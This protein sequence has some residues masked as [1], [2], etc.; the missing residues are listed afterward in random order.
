MGAPQAHEEL[1]G[2]V[3]GAPAFYRWRLRKLQACAT[4]GVSWFMRNPK[5]HDQLL[6]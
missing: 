4:R 6:P 5:L 3:L 2:K 1:P